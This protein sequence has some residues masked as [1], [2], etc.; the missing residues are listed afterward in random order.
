LGTPPKSASRVLLNAGWRVS[1][2]AAEARAPAAVPGQA[3][4]QATWRPRGRS[5]P[6]RQRCLPRPRH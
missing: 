5:R 2:Q 3:E 6:P 1:T 4:R